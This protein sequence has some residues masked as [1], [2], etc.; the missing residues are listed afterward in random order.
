MAISSPREV[1]PIERSNSLVRK[2][3]VSP[4]F[5]EA[6][7]CWLASA[8]I[9]P[10]SC[11]LATVPSLEPI[12]ARFVSRA[13]ASPSIAR[14]RNKTVPPVPR[15]GP[16]S[17]MKDGN[18]AKD[19][20]GVTLC[21][22]LPQ[23]VRLKT[24]SHLAYSIWST[25]LCTARPPHEGM[26]VTVVYALLQSWLPTHA[27]AGNHRRSERLIAVY[28]SSLRRPFSFYL[29][30]SLARL[31]AHKLV[32]PRFL[33]MLYFS[34]FP[35]RIP[36]WKWLSIFYELCLGGTSSVVSAPRTIP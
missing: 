10:S 6:A 20:T 33:L 9:Y 17:M 15:A 22:P 19:K 26:R 27:H 36:S 23:A 2:R 7:Y 32:V 24:C 30:F 3:C 1:L 13:L 18:D 25:H 16:Q 21:L 34:L 11:A 29:L 35:P 4:Y 14:F 31:Q 12:P 28:I 5:M 8:C